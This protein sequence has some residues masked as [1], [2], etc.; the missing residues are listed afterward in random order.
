MILLFASCGLVSFLLFCFEF[1]IFC[2]FSFLSKKDPQKTGH[3]KNPRTTQIAEKKDK[4]KNQL[5]QLCSQIVFLLFGGGLQ[6]C[7]SLCWKPYKNRGLSIFWESKKEKGPKICPRLSW[8]SV[9]GWVENLSN[10]VAQQNWT[11]V[12]LNKCVF[13]S[14]IFIKNRLLPAERRIFLKNRRTKK[15]KYWTGF[16]LKKGQFL[17]RISAQQHIYICIC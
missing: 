12:Q 11:D 4:Q 13:L 2:L 15:R 6:K 3:S 1:W 16:Q 14:F 5:A 10:Y 7:Y 8:T 9:Q 17:D